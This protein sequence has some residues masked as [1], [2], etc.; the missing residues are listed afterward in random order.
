MSDLLPASIPDVVR[1]EW[2]VLLNLAAKAYGAPE[3]VLLTIGSRED[4]NELISALTAETLWHPDGKHG[5]DIKCSPDT[6][7]SSDGVSNERSEGLAYFNYPFV[8]EIIETKRELYRGSVKPSPSYPFA[9]FHGLPVFDPAGRFWGILAVMD[10]SPGSWSPSTRSILSEIRLLIENHLNREIEQPAEL[11]SSSPEVADA[12]GNDSED[13]DTETT[14]TK[15]VAPRQMRSDGPLPGTLSPDDLAPLNPGQV[16]YWTYDSASKTFAF[17]SSTLTGLLTHRS[18]KEEFVDQ[19]QKLAVQ[20]M[21]LAGGIGTVESTGDGNSDQSSG[22]SLVNSSLVRNEARQNPHT[23]EYQRE[24]ALLATLAASR[25][26]TWEI[27]PTTEEIEISDELAKILA[28]PSIGR[29]PLRT[30]IRQWVHPDDQLELWVGFINLLTESRR[31]E[32]ECR[33]V[34]GDGSIRYTKQSSLA[35]VGD[36]GQIEKA[37]GIVLDITRQVEREKEIQES[38]Q[39]YQTLFD[40][41]NDAIVLLEKDRFVEVN[42]RALELFGV[43]Q[44]DIILDARPWDF[45]PEYQPNGEHSRDRIQKIMKLSSESSASHQYDWRIRRASGR[46]IDTMISFSRVPFAGHSLQLMVLRD[47]TAQKKAANM[48]ENYRAYLSVLAEIRKMFYAKDEEEIIRTFLVNLGNHFGLCKV[49]YGV[50]SGND[51]IPVQHAGILR[52]HLDVLELSL[53]PTVNGPEFPLVTAIRE[54]TFKI[55]DRLDHNPDFA[56][57]SDFVD[58]SLARSV[59]AVPLEVDGIPEGGIV[60]YSS[61]NGAFDST[62][63]DYIL[64]IIR[65]LSRI[66]WERRIWEE[67]KEALRQAKEKAEEAGEAK[68]RFLANMSHEIRTPLTA[69]LGYAEMLADPGLSEPQRNNAINVLNGNANY[70]LEILNDILDLSKIEA[71]KLDLEIRPVVLVPMLEEIIA[72]YIQKAKEKKLYLKLSNTTSF[73]NR[74]LTDSLRF[75]QIF[76]NLLSNAFKFT[77]QGGVE[78]V[79]SWVGKEG[80]SSGIVQIEILDTGVGIAPEVVPTLFSLFHQADESTTRRFGGTGL[81]LAITRRLVE[82]L[83]G[84]IILESEENV[85]TKF[86]VR[87][88]QNLPANV[89]WLKNLDDRQ[90]EEENEMPESVEQ[91]RAKVLPPPEVEQIGSAPLKGRNIL[92][93]EDGADNRRLFQ[94]IL[95]KAGASVSTAE[96]GEIAYDLAL[97]AWND[98]RPFD[99][100]I[101]DMQM[102]VMDGYTATSKLREDHYSLPIIALTAYALKEEVNRCLSAGCDDY[103]SKPIMKEALLDTVKRNLKNNDITPVSETIDSSIR[104]LGWY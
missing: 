90:T 56:N 70:L 97:Q 66:L 61:K 35:A 9:R 25:G 16:G 20:D 62:M 67:Q 88:P 38:Q 92:L 53:D 3:V 40:R 76:L 77:E 46:E 59:F 81:G 74:I 41:S 60:L 27:N 73:P 54:N 100:I 103:A 96:N 102:P 99:L 26:G 37:V 34:A 45:A 12:E 23:V 87:L 84:N 10:I 48:Y 19:I 82:L 11:S 1:D 71:D 4:G 29:I 55:L 49:W 30:F 8:Q 98:G 83:G 32:F 42:R 22:E 65:E 91:A 64:N 95:E 43:Q 52:H 2:R 78:A 85:G 33:L 36:N 17:L 58:A 21:R 72:L 14:S 50:I 7:D 94:L 5:I 24:I 93:A 101:M 104:P 18:K 31:F 28:T 44:N 79:L 63:V 86:I 89:H 13:V 57:W 6:L 75:R 15:M 80:S 51:I 68:G 39:R 47:T 69:I